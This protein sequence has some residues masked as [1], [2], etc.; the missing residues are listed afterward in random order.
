MG[1]ENLV[2]LA[3]RTPDER[4]T[5]ASK[6]GRA[7]AAKAAHRRTAGEIAAKLLA[8]PTPSMEVDLFSLESEI[9]DEELT[10]LAS[11][12]AAQVKK[13][14]HGDLKAFEAVMDVLPDEDN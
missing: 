1:S 11:M 4:R 8:M 7:R 12:V 2:S 13:A 14:M 9:P 6:G 10:V 5:I 3:D